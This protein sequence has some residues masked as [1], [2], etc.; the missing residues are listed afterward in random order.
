MTP[1]A[2]DFLQRLGRSLNPKLVRT[3]DQRKGCKKGGSK[4][5][6]EAEEEES[7]ATRLCFIL[8]LSRGD[9]E[10][11]DIAEEA[12]IAHKCRFLTLAQFATYVDYAVISQSR[13][14]MLPVQGLELEAS[15]KCVALVG[16]EC[17]P[18][19]C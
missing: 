19:S 2:L 5:D 15:C 9:D 1:K 7:R 14:E 4:G 11:V 17:D 13:R 8:K 16:S 10:F 6:D 3:A 12:F 18:H